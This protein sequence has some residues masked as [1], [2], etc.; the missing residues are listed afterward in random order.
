MFAVKKGQVEKSAPPESERAIINR[1][2]M[3]AERVIDREVDREHAGAPGVPRPV[4]EQMLR[5]KAANSYE[6]ALWLL[7]RENK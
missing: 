2:I 1:A 7:E 6:L 3:V 5:A 4:I